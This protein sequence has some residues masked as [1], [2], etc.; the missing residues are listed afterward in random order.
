M[1]LYL[2]NTASRKKELFEPLDGTT[3]KI[4]CC[5]PTVYHYAH[6]G[7]LRTF[8]FEDLLKRSLQYHDIAVNH[9]VNIT[10]V[11]HLTSD[12]DHGEDKM[13]KGAKRTGKSVWEIAQYYT[14]RFMEDCEHLNIIAPNTWCKATD[15][16]AEQ[17]KLTQI[18]EEKGFT[19]QIEDGIYFDS[20]K[21][22][23]YADFG[24]IDI[25]G[26]QEGSRIDVGGK[27]F[28]TDFALWK[29]SPVDTQRAMEW[30]SPWGTGFPGWHLECSAMAMH[31]LGETLDIH[32]GGSD[33]VKVHHT[34][35]IAQSECATGKTF[36]RFW[37]H[38]EFLKMGND[39][40]MSKSDDEFLKLSLLIEKGYSPL[41]YRYMAL[42]S[43][44]RNFLTFSWEGLEAANNAMKSLRKKIASFI[45]APSPIESA[46]AL[47]WQK[48]FTAA[49]AD[50]I[51]VPKGLGILNSMLKDSN[52][53]NAEKAALV[54]DF[55]TVLGLDLH[56]IEEE[57][58][59][60]EG[61][62][63]T[64]IEALITQRTEAKAE[65]NWGR[66]DEIRDELLAQGIV[67]KDSK[68]GTTWEKA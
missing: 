9:V 7:N 43:H 42:T 39:K 31:Y 66:C 32:C 53:A 52:V 49:I 15:H 68:E 56:I 54:L 12:S 25:D 11:G 60:T 55:D 24:K 58:I 47:K 40:K 26:L 33:L 62:D 27:K 36:S 48:D 67:L 4:Y 18:L 5:G 3:A 45:A 30:E 13:E 6:I 17:I 10:D 20:Q 51:N 16:I 61:V 14:D 59:D 21:F 8:I 2:Y 34:N 38:G 64:G 1:A 37:M 44:Y 41:A 23:R 22:E 57:I 35:E 19:Y 46:P 28:R 63:V 29:F 65:K 50:D